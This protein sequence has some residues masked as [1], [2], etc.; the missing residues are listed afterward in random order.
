M[1]ANNH[2]VND[3]FVS[4]AENMQ[5]KDAITRLLLTAVLIGT[6]IVVQ[7]IQYLGLIAL[8]II[9]LFTTAIT[10]WDP[11]YAMLGLRLADEQKS[12]TADLSE[13]G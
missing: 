4:V 3:A 2:V 11:L 9:Y 12:K 8:V 1:N 5:A 13:A 7:P 10:R 6:L